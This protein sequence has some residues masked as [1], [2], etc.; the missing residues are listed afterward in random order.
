[1]YYYFLYRYPISLDKYNIAYIL[2]DMPQGVTGAESGA[3]WG[4]WQ[5]VTLCSADRSNPGNLI[6]DTDKIIKIKYSLQ[7]FILRCVD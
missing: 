7:G 2:I 3:E 4:S 1:M 5:I 6:L